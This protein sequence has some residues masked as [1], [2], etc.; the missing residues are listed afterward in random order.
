MI[1]NPRTQAQLISLPF[2]PTKK[3]SI[4]AHHK[5]IFKFFPTIFSRH[6]SGIDDD[7]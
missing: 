1:M 6:L 3:K 4:G 7:R 2:N 5:F